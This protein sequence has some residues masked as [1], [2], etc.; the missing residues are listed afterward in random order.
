MLPDFLNAIYRERITH[1]ITVPTMLAL[2]ERADPE[3]DDAF[4]SP[5]LKCIRS[6]AG[7][8][9]PGLWERFER[10]F[11]VRVT[12]SYG[13]SETVCEATYCGPADQTYR[14][15]TIGKPVDCEARLIGENGQAVAP[16]EM[17]ELEISGENLMS[18]YDGQPEETAKV[19]SDGWLKT[20]DLA[21]LD[22]DG[23][24]RI[25]GRKKNVVIRGGVTVYPEDV[26]R[27]LLEHPQVA[28]AV[29][30][31]LPDPVWGEK[32]VACVVASGAAPASAALIAHCRETLAPEKVP[33]EVHCLETLPRGPAGK[34]LLNE[35]KE[36]VE[37][38]PASAGESMADAGDLRQRL[39]ALAAETFQ[40][41]PESLDETVSNETTPG[42]DSFAHLNLLLAVEKDFEV[43]LSPREVMSVRTLGDLLRLIERDSVD[44]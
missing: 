37:G 35:V 30:F 9:D 38:G 21:V 14:R 25:V 29:T 17:G 41:A 32:L 27:A 13:L 34:V 43:K 19:M 44:A 22:P 31:G 20:G 28:D 16:G 42:W 23:C 15:G 12:N 39:F 36:L 3:F 40:V 5:E 8:L 2:I 11:S 24:L 7:A 4:A 10:R 26:T 33:N 6:S 1:F 18:G